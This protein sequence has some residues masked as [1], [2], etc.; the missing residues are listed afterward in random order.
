MKY[1]ARTSFTAIAASIIMGSSAFAA[2]SFSSGLGGASYYTHNTGSGISSYD[3]GSDGNLYYGTNQF[4][5]FDGIYSYNGSSVTQLKGPSSDFA[6]A[7]VVAIGSSIYY[8]DSTFSNVQ[9]IY[10]YNIDDASTVS[11]NAVNYGL[12]TDGT[13]LITTGS[14]AGDFTDF[15]LYANGD[16]FSPTIN[17]GGASGASGPIAFDASGNMFYAPGYGDLSIYRWSASEVA[18]AMAGLSQL[19]A[20]GH[21]WADYSASYGSASG[22]TSMVLDANGNLFVTLTNFTDPSALVHFSPDGLSSSTLATSLDRIGELRIRDGA[23]FISD[24][25]QIL[26]VIPEPSSLLLS[27]MACGACVMV[28]RRR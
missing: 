5:M 10:R 3:W 16:L 4:Y 1:I 28:R 21:K 15:T 13:N 18:N 17:F 7:S 22:A 27:F 6:G 2:L 23:L 25:N 24:E 20:S 8:N 14:G 11:I 12:G 9:R 19:G 26:Q